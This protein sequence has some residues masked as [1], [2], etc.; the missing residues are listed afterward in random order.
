MKPRKPQPKF[1]L[2]VR[3]DG[4]DDLEPRKIY[5]V[6]E[7]PSAREEGY[8][9]V[10]RRHRA[11]ES[12]CKGLIRARLTRIMR[13]RTPHPHPRPLPSEGEGV[14]SIPSPPEGDRVRV[15]GPHGRGRRGREY[16][17]LTP[18]CSGP[19]PPAV[20]RGLKRG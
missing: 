10:L 8:R 6:L 7:D 17:A 16:I 18:R 19:A 4:C 20:R 12:G 15:R 5:Q 14:A 9:K 2:C 1:V 3:N 11:A 13:E